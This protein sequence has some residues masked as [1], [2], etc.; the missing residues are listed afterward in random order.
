MHVA[1]CIKPHHWAC[2][3]V[4]YASNLVLNGNVK[5][6]QNKELRQEVAIKTKTIIY[7]AALLSKGEGVGGCFLAISRYT[8]FHSY[9]PAYM[10]DALRFYELLMQILSGPKT[11]SVP[12]TCQPIPSRPPFHASPEHTDSEAAGLRGG[13]VQH[14]RNNATE[15]F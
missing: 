15:S 10:H 7:R 11:A 9:A 5:N 14:Y 13:W 3:V 2:E 4:C 1:T 8:A 12:G 6:C